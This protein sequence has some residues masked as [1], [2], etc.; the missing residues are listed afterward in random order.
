MSIRL[1]SVDK[2]NT[3]LL[4]TLAGFVKGDATPSPNPRPHWAYTESSPTEQDVDKTECDT[5]NKTTKD[6]EPETSKKRELLRKLKDV[7]TIFIS[8]EE[9]DLHKKRSAQTPKG[10]FVRG[11][12]QGTKPTISKN[13]FEH[14]D[15]VE[16]ETEYVKNKKPFCSNYRRGIQGNVSVIYIY[17]ERYSYL[18][19]WP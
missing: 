16:S 11:A 10:T 4:R 9:E 19:V 6:T 14:S 2:T 13:R 1:E 5:G 12:H 17:F 18:P 7:T 3:S 8:D 15:A